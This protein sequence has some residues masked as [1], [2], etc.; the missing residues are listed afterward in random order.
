[1][2]SQLFFVNIPHNCSDRELKLWIES[3]GIETS[4]IRIV[5]DLEDGVAPAFAY[6]DLK[7]YAQLAEAANILNGKRLRNQ[8]ITV[9]PS[10]A[11]TSYVP[12]L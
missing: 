4:S 3:R 7:D 8:I 12:S 1:M 10:A 5:R 2:A 6:A 9:K 11:C